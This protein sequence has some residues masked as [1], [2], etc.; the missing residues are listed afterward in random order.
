MLR[1]RMTIDTGF[2]ISGGEGGNRTLD[3]GVS[4]YNG[5]AN[6]PRPLPIA[7]N[8]SVTLGSGFLSRGESGCS[9]DVYAPDYAPPPT[10]FVLGTEARA[11]RLVTCSVS[12]LKPHPSYARH[13]LSVQPFKLSALEELGELGFSHPLM[14]TQDKCIIDGYARW[15]LAK[16]KGRPTLTCIEYDLTS[17]QALEEL[18][19]QHR[20]SHGLT[21][22]I[23][24][25]LALDLES[26]D[27][28]WLPN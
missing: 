19:R 16:R 10:E 28:L 3:T 8:Q 1:N 21:D 15:E 14:I 13:D 24:I 4:P 6:S 5:L 27:V 23:R 2:K 20:R 18:I 9:A 11:V 17:E 7:R 22:F 12:E 26:F 25:E